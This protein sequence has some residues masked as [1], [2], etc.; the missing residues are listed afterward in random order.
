[1]SDGGALFSFK[2][3]LNSGKPPDSRQNLLNSTQLKFD[4]SFSDKVSYTKNMP[5]F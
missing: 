3:D 5:I 1:M 2:V 4:M